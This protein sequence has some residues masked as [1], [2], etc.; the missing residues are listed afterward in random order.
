MEKETQLHALITSP[1]AASYT[2]DDLLLK[3]TFLD[4]TRYS[5]DTFLACWSGSNTLN[6][7]YPQNSVYQNIIETGW[8]L[9]ELFK[10]IKYGRFGGTQCISRGPTTKEA[11]FMNSALSCLKEPSSSYL[12]I[13]QMHMANFRAVLIKTDL[14][15]TTNYQPFISHCCN[16][17]KAQHK[18]Q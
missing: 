9:T 18:S 16:K 13:T 12:S 2:K 15:F 10:K 5:G 6:V 4:F 11:F 3:I 17:P 1:V 14:C 7:K 8:F